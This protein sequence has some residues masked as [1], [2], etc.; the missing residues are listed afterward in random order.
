ML[1]RAHM[2]C[3]C[4]RRGLDS[5]CPARM[6]DMQTG[7]E[8]HRTDPQ[9]TESMP[10]R[11]LPPM[12]CRKGMRDMWRRGLCCCCWCRARMRDML[13]GRSRPDTHRARMNCTV[14]RLACQPLSRQ[15]I[16]RMWWRLRARP[17][18]RA[19]THHMSALRPA[20]IVCRQDTSHTVS[21]QGWP[22]TDP[23]CMARM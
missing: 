13:C 11:L 6:T 1:N 2:Q 12:R 15:H 4:L 16:Q 22:G 20:R 17:L 21:H 9:H 8:P 18:S 23:Q 3:M 7:P 19:H 5:M 14:S 10:L